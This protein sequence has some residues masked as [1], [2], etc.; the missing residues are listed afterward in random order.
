MRRVGAHP[1][2]DLP[3]LLRARVV[4]EHLHQEAVA[5]GLGQLVD[6]LALD[7]V[8]R[9]QHQEGVGQR[10]G[11]TAD[12]HLPLGHHLEQGR[13]HLGRRAVDLVGE[14]EVG[15]HRAELGVEGVLAGL[16]DPGADDVGRHQVGGE[17]QAG[18]RPADRRGQRLDGQRLRHTRDALEQHVAAGQQADQ[19][20]LDQA[21]LPDDDP[22]DLELHPLQQGRVGG[23][24]GVLLRGRGGRA[25]GSAGHGA[26][27][28][29]RG[30]AVATPLPSVHHRR[31]RRRRTAPRRCPPGRHCCYRGVASGSS[32]RGCPTPTH[33]EP[34]SNPRH[35][36]LARPG[37]SWPGQ[38]LGRTAP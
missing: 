29:R 8:L 13:L 35:R 15:E 38:A 27:W 1:V 37:P 34:V 2:D 23:R 16:V 19:H 31:R 22:L 33:Q 25:A 36:L 32:P 28:S 18:E 14:H 21:V 7:R 10:V 20:P 4:H 3:L 17:L 9:G 24:R 11:D 6:A 26:P 5:L 12:G 30:G